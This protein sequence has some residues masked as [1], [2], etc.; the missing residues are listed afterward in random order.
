M[1]LKSLGNDLREWE[2]ERLGIIER[3]PK[4]KNEPKEYKPMFLN[5]IKNKGC[6][7]ISEDSLD[8]ER[9]ACLKFHN[10][11]KT[12]DTWLKENSLKMI[13]KNNTGHYKIFIH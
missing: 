13:E 4:I 3:P 5:V 8:L 10:G 1:S 9:M 6:F 12:F 2:N 11:E 7:F